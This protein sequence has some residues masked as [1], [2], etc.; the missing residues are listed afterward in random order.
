MSLAP[1]LAKLSHAQL[2]DLAA[3]G[4]M[5]S[6][7]LKNRADAMVAEVAPLPSWCVESV[8]LSPDLLPVLFASLGLSE[9]AAASVCSAWARAYA[10]HLRHC[11]YVCPTVLRTFKLHHPK[12]SSMLA[13]GVL[14]VS[15]RDGLQ[16]VAARDDSDPQALAACQGSALAKRQLGWPMGLEQCNDGLLVC[17]YQGGRLRKFEK[18]GPMAELASAPPP[19]EFDGG[20]QCSA[21]HQPSQRIYAVVGC[22]DYDDG[23]C[24]NAVVVMDAN[25][26]I[27]AT[28]EARVGTDLDGDEGPI[29][30]I[31][32]LDDTVIVLAN[33]FH[34]EGTG[35]RL[36]D[37]EGRH[38]RTICAGR[39]REPQAITAAHGKIYVIDS[40]PEQISAPEQITSLHVIDSAAGDTLQEIRIGVDPFIHREVASILVHNGEVYVTDFHTGEVIVLRLAGSEVQQQQAASQLSPFQ[41]LAADPQMQQMIQLVRSNPAMLQPLL[42][43]RPPPPA[44]ACPAPPSPPPPRSA[45]P[46][47]INGKSSCSTATCMT[48]P[49]SHALIAPGAAKLQPPA[50]PVH[51]RAPGRIPAAA[52]RR[53]KSLPRVCLLARDLRHGPIS[54][55]S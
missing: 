1:R 40:V 17:A 11:G 23:L 47:A 8:L 55:G 21:V 33:H 15:S 35:L 50:A 27:T 45:L 34:P 25:L 29:G 30:G 2:V 24:R 43:A 51:H 52:Q 4:C 7:E 14:A 42:Q 44:P 12:G 6:A 22:D 38:T 39:F 20:F 26:Q 48:N 5:E 9:C 37:L 31:A 13:G 19:T 53:V 3:A 54:P 41:Q 46:T 28:V 18:T 36:L 16:F 32:V 49:P 10:R